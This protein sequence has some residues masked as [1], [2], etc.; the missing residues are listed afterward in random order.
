MSVASLMLMMAS[1]QPAEPVPLRTPALPPGVVCRDTWPRRELADVSVTRATYSQVAALWGPPERAGPAGEISEYWLTCRARLWL[2]FDTRGSR[3]VR[4][5]ILLEDGLATVI[6]DDLPIVRNR[7]C[8]QVPLGRRIPSERVARAW[9][10]PDNEFGFGIVR[11][12]YDMADGGLG[13]VFPDGRYVTV[14]CHRGAP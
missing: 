10:P 12:V 8:D 13:Q 1:S 5:A 6:A 11:W 7:R 3:Q 9:G 2:V 14:T 4:R